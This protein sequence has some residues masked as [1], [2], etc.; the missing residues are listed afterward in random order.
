MVNVESH[1]KRA[2]VMKLLVLLYMTQSNLIVGIET[3]WN[4]VSRD[5]EV[6]TIGG[7]WISHQ[8][9]DCNERVGFAIHAW[10][11]PILSLTLK[12]CGI[13]LEVVSTKHTSSQKW[14]YQLT[15]VHYL[16]GISNTS[17]DNDPYGMMNLLMYL[18]Y[19]FK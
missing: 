8:D 14:V 16:F 18:F 7:C 3:L 6:K 9:G 5:I 10:L 12:P 1:I 4:I 15:F 19:F 17:Q 13:L 11:S 2:I